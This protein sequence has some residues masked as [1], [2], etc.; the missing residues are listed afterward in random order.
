MLGNN[1]LRCGDLLAPKRERLLRDRSYR[2]DVVKI[3]SC[4]LIYVRL[5]VARHGDVDDEKRTIQTLAEHRREFVRS[6]QRR[7]GRCRRDE[8]INL[9]ALHWP[10]IEGNGTAAYR[11]R[12]L[13]SAIRRT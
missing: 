12:Q 6:Q 1:H 3:N 8:N 5:H 10:L 13:T 4:H 11:L 7:F 2:I 9:T